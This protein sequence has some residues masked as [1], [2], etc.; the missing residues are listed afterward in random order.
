MQEQSSSE[1]MVQL[2]GEWMTIQN[3]SF[4]TGLS[5]ATLRRY[6]KRKTVRA[7]RLG[8][9]VNSKVEILVPKHMLATEG[10][11]LSTEGLEQV[12]TPDV[13]LSS[14]DE[15]FDDQVAYADQSTRETVEWLRDKLDDKDEKIDEL[16]RK[17]DDL[18]NHLAAATYRN[19]YL[20]SKQEDYA[21]QIKQLTMTPAVVAPEP[22]AESQAIVENNVQDQANSGGLW[23]K[24]GNWLVGKN[25]AS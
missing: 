12:L 23:S 16:R 19:G 10:E 18:T 22:P 13:E 3:A 21:A 24:L 25:S 17:L 20:E 9:T 7:R 14:E 6:I 8:K 2:E 15:E 5:M 11:R 1:K 4:A